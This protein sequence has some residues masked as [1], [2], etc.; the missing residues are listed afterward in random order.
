MGVKEKFI[1]YRKNLIEYEFSELNERQLS[2]VT[3]TQGPLL[4]LAGA[5]S[6]K[7]TVIV[8]R[9]AYM[10][11]YGEAYTSDA[12][13]DDFYDLQDIMKMDYADAVNYPSYFSVNPVKPWEILAITFTNKAAGELKERIERKLGDKGGYVNAGTFHSICSRILRREAQNL[14][15][16]SSFTIYDADDQKRVMKDI[17]KILD[18]DEKQM[19]P[20][21]ILSEISRAKD[22]LL[23]AEEYARE[24][25]IDY[26][27]KTVAKAYTEYEKRLK[28]SNAMDFDD[29]IVNTVRLFSD[30]PEV[31][32]VYQE[33]FKYVMVDEYQDTDHAQY[34]L[35][36][37]LTEKSGNICVVGDD[38]QSIYKFRGAT[39]ENILNFEKHF[40]SAEIVRLEQNYRSTGNILDAANAV[41]SHNGI[42][43]GKNL[44]TS[45]KSG[46]KVF[47]IILDDET[48]EARFVAEEILENVRNGGKFSDCAILYRTNAQSNI[49][50]NVFVR[51]GI[52]YKIIG[53][54]RFY[55]RKEIKDVVS[56]LNVIN[57]PDDDVRLRRIIN[58]PK[59]GIGE[60]T[61]AH[62]MEIASG[63]GVSLYEVFSHASEYNS[64]ARA[65]S[66]LENFTK[67]IEDLR[68]DTEVMTISE[69]LKITLE[70]TGYSDYLNNLPSLEI[71]RK[72]N[73]EELY[74]S[75]VRYEEES[76]EATLSGYL[77]EV[78]LTTDIDSYDENADTAVMMT[79]HSAKGLEFGT[80]FLV[81]ME[82][83]IFPG[84]MTLFGGIEEMEE[85]RRLA[86]VG[87]TRAKKRLYLTNTSRRL[88]YG[89]TTFNPESR[90]LREIPDE[91]IFT[92]DRTT[93]FSFSES[94]S[95]NMPK[96]AFDG[97]NY[98]EKNT[99]EKKT[100]SGNKVTYFEGE[101]VVHNTF[102]EGIILKVIPMGNDTLLEINFISVG[103]K[104]IMANYSKL[105]KI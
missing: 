34:L 104:K 14:G 30:F 74:N 95:F 43:K 65:A 89:K 32:S 6:G 21:A 13:A 90:F 36:K 82:E 79:I 55:E 1:E 18:I 50:E 42:R 24:V 73:V 8:N 101:T 53:G 38:D 22:K 35:I 49:F 44:W 71:D 19:S 20:K 67:M 77:E 88:L 28:T 9:I 75:V 99:F 41:I 78:A 91:L 17:C 81:G 103:T 80:V 33:R 16:D 7:T 105:T 62:A 58:E 59:R 23:T 29:L 94:T 68:A 85:E 86:Y 87:I 56:Y 84:N 39:I 51:A 12:V 54:Q 47:H 26:R 45:G 37:H 52:Q 10:V 46:E 93:S 27:L 3:N 100:A 60:T 97:Y 31:L 2:A 76:E 72:E 40:K 69:L 83:G 48:A 25:G 57:N 61:V 70:V 15:Y 4:I 64:L 102:G 63:L 92:D 96:S 66:K 98:P 5:G 11:K